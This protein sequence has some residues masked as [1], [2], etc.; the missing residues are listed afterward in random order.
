ML[1]KL[2]EHLKEVV[3]ESGDNM[4]FVDVDN[5]CGNGLKYSD[6]E[7]ALLEC[8]SEGP[9]N[10]LLFSL[11][12]ICLYEE[13]KKYSDDEYVIDLKTQINKHSNHAAA[14]SEFYRVVLHKCREKLPKMS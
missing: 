7:S 2:V 3:E 12:P 11:F 1:N 6:I 13:R 10:D 8:N 9:L 4:H 5:I 14:W